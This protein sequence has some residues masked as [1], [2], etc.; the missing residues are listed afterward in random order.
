M[1]GLSLEGRQIDHR[2][3]HQVV[4]VTP[5]PIPDRHLQL[6]PQIRILVEMQVELLEPDRIQGL[7]NDFRFVLLR[8][9][10]ANWACTIC[11]S[12]ALP[13]RLA[14]RSTLNRDLLSESLSSEVL[15]LEEH[16]TIIRQQNIKTS[17][18]LVNNGRSRS[19]CDRARSREKF[20]LYSAL[21]LPEF[22]V[23]IR[24]T[25]YVHRQQILR[26]HEDDCHHRAPYLRFQPSIYVRQS[27]GPLEILESGKMGR[28][29][30]L[31]PFKLM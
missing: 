19:G 13:A 14:L 5:V 22:D 2:P 17:R 10:P 25:V 26:L 24:Q 9:E 28:S 6:L 20:R 30:K 31:S 3:P 12:G 29:V 27:I 18:L 16:K 8:A 23:W 11:N 1:R 4:V 7:V 21:H 15:P